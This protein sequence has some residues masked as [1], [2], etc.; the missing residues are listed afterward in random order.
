MRNLLFKE[1]YEVSGATYG[2]C[3]IDDYYD[4]S[5]PSLVEVDYNYQ[6]PMMI[7]SQALTAA[8]FGCIGGF[9]TGKGVAGCVISGS[10]AAGAK[11][12]SFFV[13]DAYW[14]YQQAKS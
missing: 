4:Y 14:M 6:S 11:T 13:E 12:M 7:F 8:L 1:C 9:A 2:V 5:G 3:T 10:V